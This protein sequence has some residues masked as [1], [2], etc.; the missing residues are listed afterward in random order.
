MISTVAKLDEHLLLELAMS[1]GLQEDTKIS[2]HNFLAIL[3]KYLQLDF[4][5]CWQKEDFSDNHCMPIYTYPKHIKCGFIQKHTLIKELQQG[6]FFITNTDQ[7]F[8]SELLELISQKKGKVLIFNTPFLFVYLFRKESDFTT[9][10]GEFLKN[11]MLRFSDFFKLKLQ[12]N[13]LFEKVAAFEIKEKSF[14]E[15]QQQIQKEQQSVKKELTETQTRLSIMYKNMQDGIFLYNYVT[16]KIIDFNDSAFKA[17]G[18]DTREELLNQS[19]FQFTPKFSKY[20]PNIDI[21]E[22]T[23]GHGLKVCKGES[24][25]KTLGIFVGKGNKEFLVEANVVPTHQEKGEAFI[26]FRDTTE[27]ILAQNKIKLREER[28]RQIFENSH[29]AIIYFDIKEQKIVD[30]NNQ[31]LK[32]FEIE[33]KKLFF[34]NNF[35][36]FYSDQNTG[37]NAFDFFKE[38]MGVSI[39]K[40]SANFNFL[41]KTLNNNTFW[42]EGNVIVEMGSKWPRKLVFFVRDITEKYNTRQELQAQHQKLKKY[43]ESNMQLE[44]FAYVASHDLQTP[45]RTIISFTQLLNRCLIEKTNDTEK[46]YMDF[47]IKATKNMQGLIQDLLNYSHVNN[48]QNDLKETNIVDLLFEIKEELQFDIVKNNATLNIPTIPFFIKVDNYKLKQLFQNLITNALKFAKQDHPPILDISFEDK[49]THWHFTFKDNGIGIEDQYKE[50]IFLLFK[51]LHG[52]NDY[53]GTGIG[54]AICK[55][56]VEQHQGDIWFESTYGEG[57]TFYFTLKKNL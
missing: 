44:N 8:G 54:L 6:D 45:L 43:I 47:I 36:N 51:R 48:T 15:T 24:I 20:F 55:K 57:T 3:S 26:I 34:Q 38:Q 29:E 12:K 19:R 33:N 27:R 52:K 11:Q 16:E 1:Y 39:K 4:A 7:P 40:G 37:V 21:H 32:L 42:A 46:E 10:E 5:G 53:E 17:F 18:Y 56:I 49:K 41:A 14:L 30:C 23:K 25:D 22:Y 31:A 28:Y 50:K 35:E 2:A 9:E 13:I